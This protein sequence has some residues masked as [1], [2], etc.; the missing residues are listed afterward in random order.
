MVGLSAVYKRGHRIMAVTYYPDLYKEGAVRLE[1]C[2]I[3]D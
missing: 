2:K 1:R 3:A